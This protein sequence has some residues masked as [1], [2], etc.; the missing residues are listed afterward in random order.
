MSINPA[1]IAEARVCAIFV[2]ALFVI[3]RLANKKNAEFD[4][5]SNARRREWEETKAMQCPPPQAYERMCRQDGFIRVIAE[6]R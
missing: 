3:L 6:N 1:T 2:A 5:L 4:R